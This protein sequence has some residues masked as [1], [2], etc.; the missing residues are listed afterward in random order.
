M[1]SLTAVEEIAARVWPGELHAAVTLADERKGE[2][3]IL[4]T[5]HREWEKSEFIRGAQTLGFSELH[6]PKEIFHAK[7]IPIL[8]SGKVDYPSLQRLVEE[9]LNA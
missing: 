9:T 6:T 3:I 7:E 5:Q 4:V 2:K 8:G 1:V